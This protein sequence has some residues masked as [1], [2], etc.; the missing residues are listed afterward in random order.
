MDRLHVI[1]KGLNLPI[2]GQPKQEVQEGASVGRVAVIA[3]DYPFMKAKML[4]AEGDTV[5]RGQ[6]LFEDRKNPG[7]FFTAPGAGTVTAVNRGDKRALISV[8]IE[9]SESESKGSAI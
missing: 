9:L 4:V 1:K 2:K 5:R 8:V 3:D 6:R 7:V